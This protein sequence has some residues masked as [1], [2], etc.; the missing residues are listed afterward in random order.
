MRRLSR[1]FAVLFLVLSFSLIF[2]FVILSLL[3]F[4]RVIKEEYDVFLNNKVNS[5]YEWFAQLKMPA[6]DL[7]S[8]YENDNII[9]EDYDLVIEKDEEEEKIIVDKIWISDAEKTELS[10]VKSGFYNINDEVA[11]LWKY[12]SQ[13]GKIYILGKIFNRDVMEELS[14]YLGDDS[15]TFLIFDGK[16]IIPQD[17]SEYNIFIRSILEKEE[18]T[19]VMPF[20]VAGEFSN[21]FPFIKDYFLIDKIEVGDSYFYV[22]QEEALKSSVTSNILMNMIIV[23]SIAFLVTFLISAFI[24]H[25]LS[26][27]INKILKGFDSMKRGNHEKIEINSKN[28]L[29]IIASELNTTMNYIEKTSRELKNYNKELKIYSKKAREASNAKTE[30]LAN[31][32]HE[33][34]TPMNAILG[35]ADLLLN[36]E[37][38]VE[39]RKY[40]SLIYQNGEGLLSLIND[41]LDLSKIEAGK[42]EINYEPY[43]PKNLI[44]ELIETYSQLARIKNIKLISKI[45]N[46]IPESIIG[47][48]FRVRQI[49]T[50]LIS[51]SLKFTEKGYISI[52][53]EYV[54]EK[55]I[56]SVIDTGYG[57]KNENLE[58]IFEAFTQEDGT[59]SRKFGGTGLG[60]TISQK[61]ANLM[62]GEIT[63]KSTYG[64]GTTVKLILESPVMKK[65]NSEVSE[66]ISENNVLPIEE[67]SG[68]DIKEINRKILIVEDNQANRILI[69]KILEQTNFIVETAEN[70]KIGLEKFKKNN[71]GLILLD[72]QMPVMDG[73]ATIEKIRKADTHIPIIAFTAHTLVETDEKIKK[74]GFTDMLSKPVKRKDLINTVIK[75]L[76]T[77]QKVE[78]KSEEDIQPSIKKDNYEIYERIKKFSSQM[79]MNLKEAEEMFG[80]FKK[81]LEKSILDLKENIK[82][83]DYE[84]LKRIGHSIK[85]TGGMY[86]YPEISDFGKIIEEYSKNEEKEKLITTIIELQKFS[87]EKV[88]KYI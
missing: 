31:I 16:Y 1:E 56:Y 76:K 75:Y 10:D 80:E 66:E 70:G 27:I 64:M 3:A 81:Y 68:K 86:G 84:E 71:Y 2:I 21:A 78:M 88:F 53:C 46:D 17:F 13:S 63:I 32:S 57:I 87:E 54:D 59:T 49:L 15:T 47:D 18:E 12:L 67:D 52:N 50:N 42:F 85:G 28:E 65:E 43:N 58:K 39:K 11:Y 55:I 62:S 74:A 26:E 40:I 69:K 9:P 35:F 14:K 83:D 29:G 5:V 25:Y 6:K 60:L 79:D 24:N 37:K 77:P 45:S 82:K 22:I 38:N 44:Q 61:L 20:E 19:Y 73:Y 8:S 4:Q 72:L 23:L 51:N 33:I 7:I 36:Q 48:K 41:I 34:R 30:F